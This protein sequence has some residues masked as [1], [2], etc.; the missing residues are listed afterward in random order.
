MFL[1]LLSLVSVCITSASDASSQGFLA[2]SDPTPYVHIECVPQLE[3]NLVLLP[4]A[5]ESSSFVNNFQMK[6]TCGWNDM[7][8]NP[9]RPIYDFKEIQAPFTNHYKYVHT[10]TYSISYEPFAKVLTLKGQIWLSEEDKNGF[11]PY[12][13][14][15]IP[16]YFLVIPSD[17]H[18]ELIPYRLEAHI[19]ARQAREVAV[20]RMVVRAP[21]C[22]PV[23]LEEIVVEHGQTSLQWEGSWSC[24]D[25]SDSALGERAVIK[26]HV[27]NLLE[28]R[29]T[30]DQKFH[31]IV[32]EKYLVGGKLL[33]RGSASI[34]EDQ[35]RTMNPLI[36]SIHWDVA[37]DKEPPV[38]LFIPIRLP[39]TATTVK[40]QSTTK[41][42]SIEAAADNTML[43]VI[44]LVVASFAVVMGGIIARAKYINR[45]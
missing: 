25:L 45:D 7:L 37:N 18:N 41:T 15:N 22:K 17:E 35:G 10:G 6:Y 28:V 5:P 11:S 30:Y 21:T 42:A 1:V 3:T 8:D 4:K 14:K 24:S 38:N 29:A 39:G 40:Q 31:A 20:N 32:E 23:V 26:K 16:V 13:F 36:V 19:R 27:I 12:F 34:Q 9:K 43:I 2:D 44:A 33:V